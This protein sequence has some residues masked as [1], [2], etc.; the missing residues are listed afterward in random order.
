MP[1]GMKDKTVKAVVTVVAAMGT[2]YATWRC[3]SRRS[4]IGMTEKLK[5][6][7]LRCEEAMQSAKLILGKHGFADD[8]RTVTVIGF[9][10]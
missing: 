4:K 8:N 7:L 3:L 6:H 5:K 9:I 10:S 1:V 2:V